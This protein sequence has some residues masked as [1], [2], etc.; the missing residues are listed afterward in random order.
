VGQGVSHND[1]PVMVQ[2]EVMRAPELYSGNSSSVIIPNDNDK[3]NSES[4]NCPICTFRNSS[5]M[6][7]CE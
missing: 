7:Q 3:I 5:L 2:Q 4:W 6:S 1:T